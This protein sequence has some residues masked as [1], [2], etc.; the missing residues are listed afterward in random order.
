MTLGDIIQQAVQKD[1][2]GGNKYNLIY[3]EK[4]HE[5]KDGDLVFTVNLRDGNDQNAYIKCDVPY[6]GTEETKNYG[7]F[8]FL[9]MVFN[10][11]IIA[12]KFK[13]TVKVK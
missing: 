3:S 5:N 11:A 1:L 8:Y 2:A 10:A 6:D 4:V 12:Q 13:K 9:S 7:R